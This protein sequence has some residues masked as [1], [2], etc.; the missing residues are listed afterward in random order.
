LKIRYVF[1]AILFCVVAYIG[2][3]IWEFSY[4]IA[5]RYAAMY[6]YDDVLYFY[7]NGRIYSYDD[8]NIKRV[9]KVGSPFYYLEIEDGKVK[10]SYPDSVGWNE[11]SLYKEWFDEN[12]YEGSMMD[13]VDGDNI[14]AQ[15]V[16]EG[17][18]SIHI[19][20]IIRDDE[21]NFIELKKTCTITFNDGSFFPWW[22][23]DS[24]EFF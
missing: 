6:I 19:Y 18:S 1:F 24:V 23:R 22:R 3:Y 15:H 8:G 16:P 9:C 14:V 5:N 2:F 21:G 4:A 7:K 12:G 11:D 13:V 17:G 10:I 20:D